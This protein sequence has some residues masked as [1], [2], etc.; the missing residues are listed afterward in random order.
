MRQSHVDLRSRRYA[1]RQ[2]VSESHDHKPDAPTH[3]L[4]PQDEIISPIDEA[5]PR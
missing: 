5:Q 4:R 1:A 3:P 2:F